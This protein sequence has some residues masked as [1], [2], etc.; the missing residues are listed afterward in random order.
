MKNKEINIRD[1]FVLVHD[2]HYYLYGTRAKTCW[3]K[4]DG[5]DCYVGTDLE[6]WEGPFEVF[7]RPEGFWA[8][9]NYWAP[10]VHFY[11][12][13]FYMF[14]TF[15]SEAVE[16]K[17]TMILKADNPLGPFVLHSEGKITPDEWNCLDGTLYVSPEGIPYMVFCH[18]WQD[19]GDG[20]VCCVE[21]TKDLKRPAGDVRT[22]FTASQGRPWVRKIV[23]D[24][25]PGD[26]YVTDGPF[27]YRLK[28]GELLMLWSRFGEHGYVEAI[29]RSDNNDITGNWVPDEELLFERDGGHGMLFA[30]LD[31]KLMLTLHSPNETP[32]ERPAFYEMEE[33]DGKLA[34]KAVSP[35][36]DVK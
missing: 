8:D 28:G 34:V 7:H 14:A 20:A 23:H 11:E 4:A 27:L 6:N 25:F 22:L 33:R 21:L 2:G 18:E 15:N 9:K 30:T 31:G 3:G 36:T 1:P 29:S 19:I 35:Q 24:R 17:G 10:E 5:F 13:A 16:R 26:N 32:L 12:G